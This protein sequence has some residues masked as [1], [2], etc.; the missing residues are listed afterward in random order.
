MGIVGCVVWNSDGSPEI[1]N[2]GESSWNENKDCPTYKTPP[3]NEFCC[4][5]NPLGSQ[6]LP[7]RRATLKI[8]LVICLVILGYL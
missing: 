2:L 1:W 3:I 8:S 7:P 5:P 6:V 4:P